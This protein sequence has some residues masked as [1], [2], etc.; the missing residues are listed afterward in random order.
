MVFIFVKFPKPTANPKMATVKALEICQLIHSK[1]QFYWG[2]YT[3]LAVKNLSFGYSSL[4]SRDMRGVHSRS[5]SIFA[6]ISLPCHFPHHNYNATSNS[7]TYDDNIFITA[8]HKETA[9]NKANVAISR[10]NLF[11]QETTVICELDVCWIREKY[12][13]H[14]YP[15]PIPE[16]SYAALT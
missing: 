1:T 11:L 14:L 5:C 7:F 2:E 8:H 15:L 10:K 13:H 9:Y 6:T 3:E 4:K 16:G 12:S